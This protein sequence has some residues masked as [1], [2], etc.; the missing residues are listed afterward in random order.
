VRPSFET[1]HKI[2]GNKEGIMSQTIYN[3]LVLCTG[4]SARSILA[5]ALFNRL[6]KGRFKAYS[7]GSYPKGQ[8]HPGAL[9]LLARRQFPLEGLRSK[10]WNEFSGDNAPTIDFI[11]T[12]CDNAAGESCPIWPGHPTTA[13]W[14]IEDPAGAS[15]EESK[16]AFEKAY[17]ELEARIQAFCNLPIESLDSATLKEKLNAIGRLPGHTAQ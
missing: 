6:G 16:R 15:G 14:G 1:N 17:R 8:V 5:E 7:A 10:S 11:F 4:N 9:E 13:H 3:I 2:I 12:V